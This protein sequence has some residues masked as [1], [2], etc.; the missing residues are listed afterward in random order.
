M[1]WQ[2]GGLAAMTMG[3]LFSSPT[4]KSIVRTAKKGLLK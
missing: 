4:A 1:S 2:N 3:G